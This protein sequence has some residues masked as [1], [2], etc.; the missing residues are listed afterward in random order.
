[1]P[2]KSS[3][4]K[5]Q[6]E[7][8]FWAWTTI[9]LSGPKLWVDPPKTIIVLLHAASLRTRWDQRASASQCGPASRPTVA[10]WFNQIMIMSHRRLPIRHRVTQTHSGVKRSHAHTCG[11]ICYSHKL[12]YAHCVQHTKPDLRKR[13]GEG[14]DAVWTA[15]TDKISAEK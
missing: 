4:H 10:V 7:A 15:Q 13:R 11:A 6:P 12:L 5:G 3:S 1:M 8:D 2:L 9:C 14:K